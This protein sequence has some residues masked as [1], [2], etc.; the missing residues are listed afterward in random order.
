MTTQQIVL[1]ARPVGTP[2]KDTFRFETTE[3]PALQAGQVLLQGLYYSV[4]PYMRGRMSDAKSYAP[5]FEVGK[6]FYGGVVAKVLSSKSDLFKE[7]DVVL[8][9][10]SWAQQIVATEKEL[11]K[12]DT[13]IAPASYYLGILGMPGLTAYFGLMHIGKPKA[14]ETVVV[15]GAAGAVGVLVGQMANIHGCRVVGIAGT[16]EKVALIKKEF[17]F[18]EAIN[19]KTTPN[20]R[21]AIKESCPNGVDI[22]FDNVGG[23][24]SDAV[25]SNINFHARIPLCGQISLYNNTEMAMGP[26]I[27]PMLL[28]RS[29]LMQGFIVFNF[30]DKYPEGFKHLAQWVK[31]GKLKTTETIIDGFD[32]LPTALLGLFKGHN[33]GKMLVKA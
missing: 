2:T 10:L 3:V 31:E 15:S 4:D 29:V 1:A 18:D 30:Q 23:P 12:V 14:G 28:T 6:P 7:G 8:G 19:Y 9:M 24:I 32:Q 20:M 25:I 22:Y 13:T 26:R 11:R 27:Q 5:P 17:G 16:D 21:L 33:T